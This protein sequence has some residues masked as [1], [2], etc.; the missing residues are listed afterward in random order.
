[1]KDNKIQINYNKVLKLTN[2]L[3]NYV[4]LKESKG[5]DK[6]V[7]QMENCLKNKGAQPIGPLIQYTEVE[8][9]GA[10]VK[11]NV[12]LMRQSNTFVHNIEAPYKMESVIRVKNCIYARYTGEES[13]LKFA[14]DKINLIAFEEDIPLKGDSYTIFV[15]S[16]EDGIIADVFMERADDE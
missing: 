3:I 15:N 7:L 10:D 11:V 8:G 4:D 9:T 1:M 2:V 16:S 14:Y 12:K 6:E 13:K 5:L